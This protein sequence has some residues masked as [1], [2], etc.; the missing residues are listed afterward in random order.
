MSFAALIVYSCYA[1]LTYLYLQS[2]IVKPVLRGHQR[3]EQKVASSDR[4]PLKIG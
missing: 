4:C 2:N 3:E 1:S